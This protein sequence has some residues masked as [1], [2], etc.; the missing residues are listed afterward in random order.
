MP[1]LISVRSFSVEG[2]VLGVL[3][4]HISTMTVE[5]LQIQIPPRDRDDAAGD[6]AL[7]LKA[8][9][10]IDNLLTKEAQ[11][12]IIPRNENKRPNSFYARSAA[13]RSDA[14]CRSRRR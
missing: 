10:V 1:P 14:R 4:K 2:N 6:K 9:Y 3:R 11:L 7:K 8:G 12:V 5:G 13:Y